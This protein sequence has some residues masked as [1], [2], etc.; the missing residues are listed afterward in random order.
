MPTIKKGSDHFQVVTGTGANILTTAQNVFP[1]NYLIWIKDRANANNHQLIDTV[2][3]ASAV[4]QSNTTAAETTYAAPAGSSV[5]WAWKLG[6]AAVANNAGSI[7]S[8]VSAN[9]LA[10]VSVV[11]YTGT[12]ANA[13][14]GHGLGVAPKMIITKSRAAVTDWGVYH[15]SMD[16]SPQN[17]LM[18]LSSTNA[19]TV[20]AT[21]YNNTAPNS[22][23]VSVGTS[24][25]TNNSGNMLMLSFAEIAGFSKF[26]KYPGNGSS[27]GPFVY[28]GFRPRLVIVKCSSNAGSNWFV[29]DSARGS[30]NVDNARL[31]V[32][33]AG[34]EV[35][36]ADRQLDLLSNGFKVRHYNASNGDC[37]INGYTYIFAAFAE[38]P[39]NYANAR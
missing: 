39:F 31:Y 8:Q 33:D 21:A 4:L 17:G 36:D 1:G 14:V 6:G 7:A 12:G 23:V 19:Y 13:T 15:A 24:S 32:N 18:I 11:T 20:D 2:R 26:G 30:Y 29:I 38:L 5:G 27:D 28:C 16:A 37:N 35:A 3:G 34:A 25:R 22:S 9:T 10:G